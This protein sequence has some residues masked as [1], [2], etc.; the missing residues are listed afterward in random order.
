[1]RVS[2]CVPASYVTV[3]LPLPGFGGVPKPSSGL[4]I[5]SFQ[6]GEQN[7]TQ[8]LPPLRYICASAWQ[9]AVTICS[10]EGCADAGAAVPNVTA[11]TAA[12]TTPAHLGSFILFICTFPQ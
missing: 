1:M 12:A 3:A 5:G 8:S 10:G 9:S 11:A 6:T 4:P 2:V 7:P